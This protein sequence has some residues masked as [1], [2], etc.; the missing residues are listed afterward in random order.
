MAT[1]QIEGQY[2]ETCNCTFLC[3]CISSN[4][5]AR[6]TEGDCKA[7][8]AMRIDKGQKDG[9]SLDGLSFIVMLHAPGAMADGDMTVG[10]IVD[11]RASDAQVEAIG[12]IA[13][14]A[15][16]GPMANLAPLVGRIAGIE[17]RPISFEANGLD[18]AVK[19]GELV[20]QACAGIPSAV[21]PGEP[22][23]LD[24][25]MHPVNSRLGLAKATRSMFKVFGIEWR[26]RSGQR[27]GHFAPFAWTG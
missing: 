15:A 19:A 23:C 6:P 18:F 14:G 12:A 9:V 1:W 25:A 3:P 27:N 8:V 7:A 2:M 26:D 10:L 22:V 4:L 17:R 11:E 5:A 13:T 24:N 16:G 21:K 20:D